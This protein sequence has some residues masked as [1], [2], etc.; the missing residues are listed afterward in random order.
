VIDGTQYPWLT[1]E[2]TEYTDSNYE[3]TYPRSYAA[4][5]RFVF[6]D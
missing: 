4:G 6:T 5:I 2:A 3:N 1:F